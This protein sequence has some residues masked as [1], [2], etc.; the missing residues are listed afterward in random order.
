[1][2]K[3]SHL[4]LL[5][6]AAL[7]AGFVDSIAGG[8]GLITVPALL[9]CGLDPRQALGTNKLQ[10]CFGSG[11]ATRHFARA[12]MVN[13]GECRSGVAFTFLGAVV[14]TLTVQQL[15]PAFLRRFIPTLLLVVA[16]YV[17]F[18]P[19]LGQSDRPPRLP[20]GL[21]NVLF[22]LGLGFYDGFFGPGVGTFWA[23]A[24]VL[25]LGCNLVRAT[26]HTKVMNF[27]SN[28]ASLLIFVA[29]GHVQF[30]A[31]LTMGAGQLLGARLGSG[32]VV[33][34]GTCFIRPIFLTVVLA[35]SLKL[36]FDAHRS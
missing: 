17:L 28:V 25:G 3:S 34:K 13:W 16:L 18:K 26:A 14:G 9:A 32:M 35:L 22:G 15:D 29:G 12:G 11:S 7:V 30:A 10:A 36:L 8:G 23:M 27:A 4:L 2:A 31:G 20:R 33:K 24:F 19:T 6:V 1:V 5:F 21:F